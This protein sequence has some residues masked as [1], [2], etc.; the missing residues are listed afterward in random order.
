M[1]WGHLFKEKL[2]RRAHVALGRAF[3]RTGQLLCMRTP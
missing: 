2:G 1:V 3:A